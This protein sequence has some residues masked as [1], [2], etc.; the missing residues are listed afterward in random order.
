MMG[1]TRNHRDLVYLIIVGTQLFGMLG[2]S[3]SV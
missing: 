2:R 1:V 3:I